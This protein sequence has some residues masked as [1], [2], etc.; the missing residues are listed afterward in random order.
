MLTT[1][2]VLAAAVC[3]TVWLGPTVW[4]GL[5][6]RWNLLHPIGFLPLMMAYHLLPPLWY[7]W[8]GDAMLKTSQLWVADEWFLAMPV[9]VIAVCGVCYHAGVWLSGASLRLRAEDALE[10]RVRLPVMDGV[11][12]P[13]LACVS[14]LV[15]V[16]ATAMKL[17]M[18]D[19]SEQGYYWVHLLFKGFQLAPLLVFQRS[20]SLGLLV[21]LAVLPC[22]L[23]LRSKAAFL[24]IPIGFILFYQTR[25]FALSKVT[26]GILAGLLL[27]TPVAGAL[28]SLNFAESRDITDLRHLETRTWSEAIQIAS[29]REY[30]VE[31]FAC[32]Y[33]WR[34]GHG[35]S[36]YWGSKT[37]DD[38]REITP[39]LL[40]PGKPLTYM[41]IPE[42]YF[43]L[44]Y[45]ELDTHY[46]ALFLTP[47]FLDFDIPGCYAFT[48]LIGLVLG[49]IYR[50]ARDASLSRREAWPLFLNLAV[51]IHAKY[52]IEGGL[53]GAIPNA[54]G[55]VCGV[56][57]IVIGSRVLSVPA[58]ARCGLIR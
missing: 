50:K 8:D 15:V 44:D 23:L 33:Q 37:F 47:V 2:D 25:L 27:L 39:S 31:G 13:T 48:L 32:V 45:R 55:M 36:L 57:M 58:A 53:S 17:A 49:Y 22:T 11:S 24:Y 18:T 10:A 9:L 12:G 28:Y 5:R 19:A 34:R 30:A 6:G 21:L 43:P 7:R 16:V 3:V 56:I 14:C 41:D 4:N 51:V 52:L 54:F 38:L 46:A 42:T 40:W 29:A 26:I 20:R 1:V 35:E